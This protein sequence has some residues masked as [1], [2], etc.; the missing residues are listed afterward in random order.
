LEAQG[1]SSGGGQMKCGRYFWSVDPSEAFLA[2]WVSARSE[3]IA[4]LIRPF[5]DVNK[6]CEK[7]KNKVNRALS[8]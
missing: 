8:L 1:E 2:Q 7:A 5:P 6:V 3:S 4:G